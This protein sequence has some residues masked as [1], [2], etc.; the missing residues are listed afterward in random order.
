MSYGWRLL[1]K[2]DPIY[3]PI[4][5]VH[6]ELIACV[7]D[8]EVGNCTR[9]MSECMTSLPKWARDAPYHQ[10]PLSVEADYGQNYK[11]LMPCP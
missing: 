2:Q 8:E 9:V 4:M 11:D 6:D 10:L 3:H 5:T 1:L 7:P